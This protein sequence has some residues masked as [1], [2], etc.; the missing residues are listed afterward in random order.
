MGEGE[1]A[2]AGGF[3]WRWRGFWCALFFFCLFFFFFRVIGN[4]AGHMVHNSL[5]CFLLRVFFVALRAA[6]APISI[7]SFRLC[8]I[9]HCSLIQS[10][11]LVALVSYRCICFH[12]SARLTS[13]HN[14][15]GRWN[16][17]GYENIRSI[18]VRRESQRRQAIEIT[19]RET[20][21]YLYFL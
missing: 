6:H 21:W 1:G 9:S 15:Q 16:V 10:S 5:R 2:R 18:L 11:S 19:C 12:I 7:S 3:R 4:V 17:R 8:S 20:L 13:N 14:V